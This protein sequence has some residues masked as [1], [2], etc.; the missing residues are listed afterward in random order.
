MPH[1]LNRF[2]CYNTSIRLNAQP[3][4]RVMWRNLLS[5]EEKEKG[6]KLII[7]LLLMP[8]LR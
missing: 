3:E 7:H 6:I 5:K 8:R 4:I 1:H 2:K